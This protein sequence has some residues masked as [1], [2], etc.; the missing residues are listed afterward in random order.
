M[1]AWGLG[2]PL[3]VWRR[4]PRVRHAYVWFSLGFVLVSLASHLLLGECVLT[5]WAHSL[6]QATGEAN[7]QVPF[8]VTFTNR[9]AGVRPSTDAAVLI[10]EL[11]IAAYCVLGLWGW[12]RAG[13]RRSDPS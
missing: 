12:Q 8:V 4:W 13:R 6:W 7:Q 3:L 2:L 9:I 10:W 5:L 1:L 11:A